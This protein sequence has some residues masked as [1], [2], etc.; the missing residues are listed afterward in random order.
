L[1]SDT[2]DKSEKIQVRGE[3]MDRSVGESTSNSDTSN[4]IMPFAQS[5]L[6]GIK[7]VIGFFVMSEDE[8][9]QAGIDLGNSHVN[10]TEDRMNPP[11]EIDENGRVR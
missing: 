9:S 11:A 4:T 5:L 6:G 2:Y 1:E 8:M 3:Q 10:D 7:R